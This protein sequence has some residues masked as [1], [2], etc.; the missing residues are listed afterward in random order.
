MNF[1]HTIT[2]ETLAGVKKAP[3]SVL[4]DLDG[5]ILVKEPIEDVTCVKIE[6]LDPSVDVFYVTDRY[7]LLETGSIIQISPLR[8]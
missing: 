1:T 3:V 8:K 5:D 2:I 7:H 4:I 6:P